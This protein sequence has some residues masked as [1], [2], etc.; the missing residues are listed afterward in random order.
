MSRI[1]LSGNAS[2][3]GNF[4]LASPGTNTDRTLTLPDATGTVNISGLANQVPAGSAGAPAIYPTGD[5]DTGIYFPSANMVGVSTGGALRAYI[6]SGGLF[7][8]GQLID[9]MAPSL[10]TLRLINNGGLSGYAF[11]E[12]T[13]NGLAA[14]SVFDS[15][16]T[17]GQ[18]SFNI[19]G[20]ERLRIDAAGRVTMPSQPAFG[21]Y[22]TAVLGGGAS[23]VFAVFNTVYL[24]RGSSYNASNGR[25]TAPVTGVYQINFQGIMTNSTGG[26]PPYTPTYAEFWVNG[27][28]V[29]GAAPYIQSATGQSYDN[30]SASVVVPMNAGDF[31]NIR[32]ESGYIYG[33]ATNTHNNFSG[34]LIG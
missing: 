6:D 32:I 34:Y 13:G 25:F 26:A 22:S 24:N 18:L 1:T 5:T 7:V 33:D 20:T 14:I 21:A 10:P 23:G 4:T 2:G 31:V 29:A 27:V 12:M 3:T 19:S 28:Q 8:N 15:T 30:L 9:I 17:G 11:F 16:F